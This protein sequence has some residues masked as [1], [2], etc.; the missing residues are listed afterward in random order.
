MNNAQTKA[1]G[2]WGSKLQSITALAMAACLSL[3]AAGSA[4]AHGAKAK[5]GGIIKEVGDL[6]F[7][8]VNNQGNAKIYVEDHDKAV[9][10]AGATGKLTVL[11]GA[12]KTVVA[13]EAAGEN[14]LETKTDAKLAKGAKVVAAVTFADKKTVTVRFT[15][16]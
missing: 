7:E 10:T 1:S 2:I 13:L 3:G 9:A 15:I 16:K 11:N 12:E 6:R 8:L 4:M 14:Q 5:H